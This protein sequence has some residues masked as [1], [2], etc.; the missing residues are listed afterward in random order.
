MPIFSQSNSSPSGLLG[1]H[2][3]SNLVYS[4]PAFTFFSNPY[5]MS[6]ALKCISSFSK[7]RA[8]NTDDL[9][10]IKSAVPPSTPHVYTS[11]LIASEEKMGKVWEHIS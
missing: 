3:G 2:L 11:L 1:A 8:L 5:T 6:M 4:A 9:H 7:V 10:H